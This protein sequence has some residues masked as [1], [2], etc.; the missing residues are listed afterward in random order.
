MFVL[1]E[2]LQIQNPIIRTKSHLESL[3]RTIRKYKFLDKEYTDKEIEIA[4][5]KFYEVFDVNYDFNKK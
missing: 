4:L 2:A 1:F 3:I 5:K